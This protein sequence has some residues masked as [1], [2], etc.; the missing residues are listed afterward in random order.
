M[1][2]SHA[3]SLQSGVVIVATVPASLAG[4]PHPISSRHSR[5]S[6]ALFHLVTIILPIHIGIGWGVGG[7]WGEGDEG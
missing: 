4:P 6:L 5:F 1:T 3:Y 2:S 7:E